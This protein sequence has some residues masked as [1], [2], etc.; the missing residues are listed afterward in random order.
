LTAATNPGQWTTADFNGSNAPTALDG[1]SVSING[2]PAYIWYLS[3]EQINVQAPT[4]KL[5]KQ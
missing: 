4:P 5:R 3:A 2:K 1:V